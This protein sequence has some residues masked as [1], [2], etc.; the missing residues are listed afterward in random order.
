MSLILSRIAQAHRNVAPSFYSDLVMADSPLGYW[1][2][3]E[4]SGT[5]AADTSGNGHD[6]TYVSC[7]LGAPAIAN[8]N[9]GDLAV[10][11]NATSSQ[12]TVGAVSALYGLNR[13]FAIEAWIKP[14]DVTKSSGI[15][16]AGN[17]GF[18]M[19][20]SGTSIE[21]LRDYV[22]SI[23]TIA[24][25]F[26][27]GFR[28]HVVVEVDSAGNYSL[29]VNGVV[30]GTGTFSATFTGAYLRLGADGKDST[31]VGTFLDGS[32][33][34]IAVYSHTLGATRVAAHYQKGLKGTSP[35]FWRMI[36]LLSN[37]TGNNASVQE[38][39][40]RTA[41]GGT[42]L[43]LN[44]TSYAV[45]NY[46]GYL[47]SLA[48]DGNTTL[49]TAPECYAGNGTTDLYPVLGVMLPAPAV[50]NELKLCARHVTP[51]QSPKTFLVQSS[52]DSTN[53]FDGTW[54]NEWMVKDQTSWSA[55]EI[56]TFARG[57]ALPYDFFDPRIYGP[58]TAITNYFQTFV[59]T[60]SGYVN[61]QAMR[62]T[63]SHN[64]GK[65]FGEF[66]LNR[67]S[68]SW[69]GDAGVGTGETG[70]LGAAPTH[71]WHV[72][73]SRNSPATAYVS[74]DGTTYSITPNRNFASG[75]KLDVHIDFDAG[76]GWIRVNGGY[77]VG[78]TWGATCDPA[79]GTNPT[80][81]FTPNTTLYLIGSSPFQSTEITINCGQS[82]YSNA[83][84]AGYANW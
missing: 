44:A 49:A 61:N 30:K 19:R 82:A 15:W 51:S 23:T 60:G 22:A 59:R 72:Q 29:Y 81:T 12:I 77:I 41:T 20:R 11:G 55:G 47:P 13:S 42:N 33:D 16:S 31:T 6:G 54:T 46:T 83:P 66:T 14:A 35:Q 63:R 4:T 7:T 45:S 37:A 21:F 62:S 50:I 69:S 32:I 74:L 64:T 70:S 75:A 27:N 5:V 71:F 65:Y 79:T 1:K 39:E 58:Q 25:G 80:F 18:C 73:V 76:K 68:N 28:Y 17:G 26:A 84:A 40:M 36:T 57:A 67:D 8:N 9:N 24:C 56:R 43:A 10:L 2:L 38:L 48:F 3:G 34:E 52:S 78:S 53:G